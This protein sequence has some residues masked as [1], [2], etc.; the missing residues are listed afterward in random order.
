MFRSLRGQDPLPF[1]VRFL[2]GKMLA[3]LTLLPVWLGSV[4]SQA[5][6]ALISNFPSYFLEPSR[7]SVTHWWCIRKDFLVLE[8]F[9]S[10]RLSLGTYNSNPH[11]PLMISQCKLFLCYKCQRTC[12]KS[13]V[14]GYLEYYHDSST[15]LT[16][17]WKD[18]QQNLMIDCYELG[19]VLAAG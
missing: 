6:F 10:S 9:C 11:E 8:L 7:K 15:Q 16:C 5:N 13:S 3:S 19:T 17:W 2:G 1:P 4:G 12:K 18:F 14:A